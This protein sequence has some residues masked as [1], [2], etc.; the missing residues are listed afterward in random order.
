[1]KSVDV[2]SQ[3]ILQRTYFSLEFEESYENYLEKEEKDERD[4]LMA[5]L[6]EADHDKV[7]NISID[8]VMYS[9]NNM[10]LKSRF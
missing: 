2:Q 4:Y 9:I 10:Y 7:S 3:F 5:S 1:M 6:L 8:K